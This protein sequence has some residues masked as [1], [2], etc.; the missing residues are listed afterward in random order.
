MFPL[1][2]NTYSKIGT[3]LLLFN[4]FLLIFLLAGGYL[5]SRINL[6]PDQG[7]VQRLDALCKRYERYIDNPGYAVLIDYDLP[8][9]LKRL[10]V[11]DLKTNEPALTAHVS[12]AWRSGVLY[13]HVFSN[14]PGSNISSKGVF[15]SRN[16]YA[17]KY[18]LGMRIQG[19]DKGTNDNVL[20]RAIVFHPVNHWWWSSG[21]FMT[22]R[23]INRKIIGMTHGGS[24]IYV[25][26]SGNLWEALEKTFSCWF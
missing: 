13:P 12:H 19:L 23:E 15:V 17:G 10:W 22:D 26:S 11:I 20:K 25:H 9:F 2:K 3:A 8:V 24:L 6:G 5:G 14:V 21:C 4:F 18:G 1:N 7:L 16:S